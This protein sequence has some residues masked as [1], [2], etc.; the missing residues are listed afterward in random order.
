MP[1]GSKYLLGRY[2]RPF[3]LPK[4]HPQVLGPSAMGM[5]IHSQNTYCAVVACSSQSGVASR[6]G[7]EGSSLGGRPFD[8]SGWVLMLGERVSTWC[9]LV[10]GYPH[11]G[12]H[13]CP[14]WWFCQTKGGRFLV[15]LVVFFSSTRET[16]LFPLKRTPMVAPLLHRNPAAQFSDDHL[17]TRTASDKSVSLR[18]PNSY[19]RRYSA[20]A[21]V[22]SR[23]PLKENNCRSCSLLAS[24]SRPGP[25]PS[26]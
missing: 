12:C 10:G 24:V 20:H 5:C 6:T 9:L 17:L 23:E 8:S 2:L 16:H 14:F 4:S 22:Y 19:P 15:Y 21:Y 25:F 3:L 18:H 7:Q 13:R 11:G 1:R 26:S